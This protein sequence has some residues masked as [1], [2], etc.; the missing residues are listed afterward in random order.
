MVS[1]FED[2]MREAEQRYQER[3]AARD[4]SLRKIRE[5]RILDVETQDRL[6]RRIAGLGI[7]P[8]A[9]D[10]GPDVDPA[11]IADDGNG[12][13]AMRRLGLERILGTSDLMGFVFLEK[14]Y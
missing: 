9:I 3:G 12:E 7:L 11:P 5:R 14:G 8:H 13:G 2:L 4:E 1:G 10:L 6:D